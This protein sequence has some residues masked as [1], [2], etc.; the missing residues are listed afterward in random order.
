MRRLINQGKYVSIIPLYLSIRAINSSSSFDDAINALLQLL[1]IPT[2]FTN[3]NFL[4]DFRDKY[5]YLILY[6]VIFK[7]EARDCILPNI[8]IGYLSLMISFFMLGILLTLHLF[9]KKIS[10]KTKP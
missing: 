6:L 2:S 1:R 3:D 7:N 10:I 5:L 8:R 9:D 4:K